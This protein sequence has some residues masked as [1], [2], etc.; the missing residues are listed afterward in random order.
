[1]TPLPFSERRD[2][3]LRLMNSFL[4]RLEKGAV[5]IH[6]PQ[7]TVSVRP[8][9]EMLFHLAPELFLQEGGCTKF[10]CPAEAFNLRAEEI[11]LIPRAVPHG[12][13]AVDERGR[14]FRGLVFSID[15]RVAV[16]SRI[17]LIVTKASPDFR[18]TVDFCDRFE[19]PEVAAAT[20]YLDGAASARPGSASTAEARRRS[21]I[22]ASIST[23]H[24]ALE[25]GR[26]AERNAPV[27]NP[28]VARC[29]ELIQNY[30]PNPN[31]TVELLARELN[32]TPDHLSRSFRNETGTPVLA[33][34]R[35]KRMALAKNLMHDPKANISEI[36]WA[37]GF[38]SLN[39]FVRTFHQA[40]GQPPGQYRRRLGARP[41]NQ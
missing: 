29:R 22:Y 10:S 38:N 13:V 14:S 31:L 16:N 8:E 23:L 28:K 32:C 1:M 35:Q 11:A 4:C 33:Y 24:D 18:P 20:S 37:C 12:E 40:V 21:L 36:A 7:R 15:E 26:L 27:R 5:R 2:A 9:P 3:Y 30:L 17:M 6:V 34:V 25:N 41:V 19:A 39:Y